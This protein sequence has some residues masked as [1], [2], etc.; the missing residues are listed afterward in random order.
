MRGNRR[1]RRSR[2]S[3]RVSVRPGPSTATQTVTVNT[4]NPPTLRLQLHPR[5]RVRWT[6]DTHDN[7]HE[8]KRSS[9]SCCIYHKKRAWDESSSESDADPQDR[10]SDGSSSSSGGRRRRGEESQQMLLWRTL[11]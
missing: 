3:R 2:P 4:A 9:K 7:E 1:T 10:S 8:G 11:V 5:R 6:S